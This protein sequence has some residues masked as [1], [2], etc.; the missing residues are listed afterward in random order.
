MTKAAEALLSHPFDFAGEEA[1]WLRFGFPW[2]FQSDLLDALEALAACGYATDSRF[3]ALAQKVLANDPGNAEAL[4]AVGLGLEAQDRDSE[5]LSYYER[6]LRYMP[7][8]GEIRQKIRDL[9]TRQF[10]R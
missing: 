7:Q 3:R 9:R 4:Y 10:R 6:A 5:A 8:S 2:Y 1:R